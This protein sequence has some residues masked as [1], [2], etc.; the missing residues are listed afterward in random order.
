MNRTN[1]EQGLQHSS[2][3]QYLALRQSFSKARGVNTLCTNL[4][5]TE[6]V[7]GQARGANG[8]AANI[9]NEQFHGASVTTAM[10]GGEVG[11]GVGAAVAFGVGVVSEGSGVGVSANLGV[12]AAAVVSS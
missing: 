6:R 5:L 2:L 12:A 1:H 8:V 3:G 9:K 11:S 4:R 10:S 7:C